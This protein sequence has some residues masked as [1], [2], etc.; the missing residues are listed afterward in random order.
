MIKF[1]LDDFK[2]HC[3]LNG[4]DDIGLT[5][6]KAPSIDSFEKQELPNR[7]LDRGALSDDAQADL[8]RLALRE[9]RRL[10]ARRGDRAT[11]ASSP[12]PPATTMP[13]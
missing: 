10:F 6:E 3:L 7:P 5:L 13:P 12:A 4:L 8:H 1:D 11:G 2:R 9:D